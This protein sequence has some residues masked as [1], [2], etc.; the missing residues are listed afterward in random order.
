MQQGILS[1]DKNARRRERKLRKEANRKKAD[2][3]AKLDDKGS[4]G[5]SRDDNVE[6]SNT[7]STKNITASLQKKTVEEVFA[8]FDIDGSGLIDFDEFRAMLPQ[9]G[10]NIS[11][12]KVRAHGGRG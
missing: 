4:N 7:A 1:D 5:G 11:M 6:R 10:I 2:D 3:L 9:L 12:P 8:Q